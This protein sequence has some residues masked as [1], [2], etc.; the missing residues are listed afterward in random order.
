MKKI[1]EIA[2]RLH[3]QADQEYQTIS[4]QMPRKFRHFLKREPKL[5]LV[6]HQ[7]LEIDDKASELM[8]HS[9]LE[10][11]FVTVYVPVLDAYS[12]LIWAKDE[13]HSDPNSLDIEVEHENNKLKCMITSKIRG[14]AVNELMIPS[15]KDLEIARINLISSTLC[16]L[17]YGTFETNYI[18]TIQEDIQ[19]SN[20]EIE[21][22]EE[23]QI[24]IDTSTSYKI[25]AYKPGISSTALGNYFEVAVQDETNKIFKTWVFEFENA[26]QKFVTL[27]VLPS[28]QYYIRFD[29]L[30]SYEENNKKIIEIIEK[31]G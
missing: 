20:Q 13:H 6:S 14:S 31:V 10:G 9:S 2:E 24:K 11:T 1:L 5:I 8:L 15:D 12:R 16:L 7:K 3:E 18:P 25:I 4:E 21:L 27:N 19:Q 28:Q 22:Y 26:Y 23:E 29:E 17:G 30:P